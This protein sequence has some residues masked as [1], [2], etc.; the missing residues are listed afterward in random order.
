M[1]AKMPEPG[2]QD[3]VTEALLPQL[4]HPYNCHTEPDPLVENILLLSKPEPRVVSAAV[5]DDH[6]HGN[7]CCVAL[8]VRQ[9]SNAAGRRNEST[10]KELQATQSEN[11]KL[12]QQIK[13]QFQDLGELDSVMGELEA[14]VDVHEAVI[15]QQ[16]LRIQEQ[17]E[18]IQQLNTRMQQ[19]AAVLVCNAFKTRYFR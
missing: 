15:K 12:R 8:P 11:S 18:M 5:Q 4:S 19:Y 2:K 10:D 16:D 7:D 17:E 6:T 9:D 3:P 1:R 14:Q 13:Q